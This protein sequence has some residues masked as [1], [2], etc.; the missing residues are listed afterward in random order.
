[1]ESLSQARHPN[2]VSLLGCCAEGEERMLVYEYLPNGTVHSW[3]HMSQG[4]EPIDWQ[5]RMHI[6]IGCARG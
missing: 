6:A 2:L 4:T 1:M 5:M 3:L